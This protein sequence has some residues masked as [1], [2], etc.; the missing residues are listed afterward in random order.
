MKKLLITLLLVGFIL[1]PQSVQAYD[2]SDYSFTDYEN[3][4]DDINEE[5]QTDYALLT[6]E[7][8]NTYD[9][10]KEV[11]GTYQNYQ[12]AVL[13]LSVDEFKDYWLQMSSYEVVAADEGNV[14]TI[15]TRST[16][17][18]K[19]KLFNN[20]INRMKLTYYYTTKSGTRYFD[21]TKKP[22][23]TV[24]KTA[25]V[26]YFVMSSYTGKYSN[27]NKRYTVTAKGTIYNLF[28]TRSGTFSVVFDA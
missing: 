28:G 17:T 16:R 9:G 27:S 22:T 2:Y 21:T 26:D 18:T 10:Y 11:Y 20:S 7:D 8:F 14:S 25:L 4:L 23:V 6:K 15:E 12:D 5:Y 3:I 24:E 1:I 13:A 19:S